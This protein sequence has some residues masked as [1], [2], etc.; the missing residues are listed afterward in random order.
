MGHDITAKV[1]NT[2]IAYLRRG[3]FN[4]LN[5]VIYLSLGT[6]EAYGGVSGIG[7]TINITQDQI[8][9]AIEIL[10]RSDVSSIERERTVFDGFIAGLTGDW[11]P[12]TTDDVDVSPELEFLE[13]C[14]EF[15]DATGLG[16]SLE[17]HF[18]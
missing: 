10:T 5:K 16:G 17:V 12:T 6:L 1:G 18:G 2:E 4:P 15:F 13:A 7:M 14:R 9:A 3:A 11:L 8:D